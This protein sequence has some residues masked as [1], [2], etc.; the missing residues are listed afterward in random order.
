MKILFCYLCSR[1]T[2]LFVKKVNTQKKA[3]FNRLVHAAKVVISSN[4]S[5]RL[6]SIFSKKKFFLSILKNTIPTQK[7]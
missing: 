3:F 4:Q 2:C 1:L 5:N 7:H 6:T